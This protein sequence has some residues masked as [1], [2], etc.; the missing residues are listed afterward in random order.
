MKKTDRRKKLSALS[1]GAGKRS[2]KIQSTADR[3]R[4]PF[5]PEMKSM[6]SDPPF[7]PR[8]TNPST[9]RQIF[10][11][12]GPVAWIEWLQ[13][14]TKPD[15]F[16]YH[17]IDEAKRI[18]EVYRLC[19]ELSGQ[20]NVSIIGDFVAHCPHLVLSGTWVAQVAKQRS[21]TRPEETNQ[22]GENRLLEAIGRGFR[23]AASFSWERKLKPSR[24]R[25]AREFRSKINEELKSFVET[26][27]R[28]DAE[29]DWL[30]AQIK[31]KVSELVR[32]NP[33]LSS[34]A[35]KLTKKLSARRTYDASILI[36]ATIFD[37]RERDLEAKSI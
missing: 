2:G 33:R 4:S 17:P 14:G 11:S 6:Q 23:R 5:G 25:A 10:E 36:A 28:R 35:D 34:V 9:E 16:A 32:H 18:A 15:S 19:F 30:A 1:H 22:T 20:K 21:I 26:L 8:I 37:I 29:R 24:L 31:A 12:K 3:E 27:R 7:W 13:E